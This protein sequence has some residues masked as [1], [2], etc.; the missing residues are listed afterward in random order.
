MFL[1]PVSFSDRYTR[2][3]LGSDRADVHVFMAEEFAEIHRG[4]H[5]IMGIAAIL[6]LARG[7]LEAW[8]SAG[9]SWQFE[10][11]FRVVG[12]SFF[13]LIWFLYGRIHSSSARS[14]LFCIYLLGY[15]GMTVWWAPQHGLHIA[16]LAVPIMLCIAFGVLMWPK[17]DQLYLPIGSIMAPALGMLVINHASSRDWAAYIFYFIVAI[18]FS[19]VVR[20]TRLRTAFALF[21]FRENLRNIADRDPL[22]GLLNRAGW[23]EQA[24]VL[25]Q[26]CKD[27]GLP[28]CVAFFDI[29][30]FKQVNDVHGHATGDRVLVHV[31]HMIEQGFRP[32][33]VVG[34][35]GGEEFVAAMLGVGSE[36][37]AEIANKLRVEI[38]EA[39]GPVPVTVSVGVSETS[40]AQTL[41]EVM[42]QADLG[43]LDAK[44]S[45]RNR[46]VVL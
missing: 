27:S 44:R 26:A 7:L 42:H 31:A 9:P 5:I 1:S 11:I 17:I 29:D 45:G 14:L 41:P 25:F 18:V 4:L 20:R 32:D 22:T 8:A 40:Q 24:E 36:Q 12:A 2:W 10:L 15:I 3:W 35:L 23:H 34:R 38:K 30:H 19:V 28:F 37:G 21:L 6:F 39:R 46:V 16:Y 33:D 13:G 43:M